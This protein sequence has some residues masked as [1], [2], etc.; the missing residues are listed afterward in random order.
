MM[1]MDQGDGKTLTIIHTNDFHNQLTPELAELIRQERSKAGP[2][3]ILLDSGDAISAGNVGVRLGGEPI[4]TL[5]S[6]TGYDAMT[7]GNR[8]YHISEPALRHKIGNAKF[9]VLSANMRFKSGTLA[10]LPVKPYVVF[11]SG[12]GIKVCVFGLTVAMVTERMTARHLSTFVFDD[13]IKTALDLAP[14]LRLKADVLI[15]LSHVG[16]NA[17][18]KIAHLCPDI[19]LI[20]GGHSHVVLESADTSCGVPVVQAGSFARYLGRTDL[21]LASDGRWR[22]HRSG[23]LP[24]KAQSK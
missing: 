8:E 12:T 5:M 17:D 10:P 1:D 21:R 7:M 16:F 24:L 19:D 13:P 18:L 22:L 15:L 14:Q 6:E 2:D 4:L 11:T 23:L 9:P 20:V 3:A